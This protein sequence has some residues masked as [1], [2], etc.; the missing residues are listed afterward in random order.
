VKSKFHSQRAKCE[1][2]ET[3][4]PWLQRVQEMHL[5]YGILDEDIYNFDKT[6]F[7]MRVIATSK[8]VTSSD[9]VAQANGHTT[10]ELGVDNSN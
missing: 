4:N 10:R 7:Q 9:T 8:V 2:P 5:L 6:G 3:I 1:V